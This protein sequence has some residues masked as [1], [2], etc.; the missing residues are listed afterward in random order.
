MIILV[1]STASGNDSIIPPVNQKASLLKIYYLFYNKPLK[2]YKQ[3][4][5]TS[6]D[7]IEYAEIELNKLSTVKYNLAEQDRNNFLVNRYISR[8]INELVYLSIQLDINNKQMGLILQSEN[9][10]I[11]GTNLDFTKTSKKCIHNSEMIFVEQINNLHNAINNYDHAIKLLSD[12]LSCQLLTQ[13]E[14]EKTKEIVIKI[15]H[16]KIKSY[17]EIAERFKN[18]P[19]PCFINREEHDMF[20]AFLKEKQCENVKEE[21]N[22]FDQCMDICKNIFEEKDIAYFE[23]QKREIENKYFEE[24]K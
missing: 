1:V 8:L 13:S 16:A 15:L 14:Q 5:Q 24:C 12:S 10:L 22:T 23:N 2:N 20:I 17:A 9:S 19:I 4:A 6:T 21:L 7:Y 11:V 18:A 3:N